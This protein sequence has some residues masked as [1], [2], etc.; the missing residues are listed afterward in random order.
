MRLECSKNRDDY[1]QSDCIKASNHMLLDFLHLA[2]N[3]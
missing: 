3:R 1:K 2:R